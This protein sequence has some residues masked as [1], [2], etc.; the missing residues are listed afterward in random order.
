MLLPESL[1]IS[2]L[3]SHFVELIRCGGKMI[4]TMR[5]SFR[6]MTQGKP[7]LSLRKSHDTK[8]IPAWKENLLFRVKFIGQGSRSSVKKLYFRSHLTILQEVFEA[9]CHM[10]QGQR[11]TLKIEVECYRVKNDFRFH[12]TVLLGHM[13]QHQR[14]HGSRS[15]VTWV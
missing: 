1:C 5:D 9:M 11:L 4:L 15:K 6:E 14:S 2:A 7:L 10:G 12:L 8:M 13:G 3:V